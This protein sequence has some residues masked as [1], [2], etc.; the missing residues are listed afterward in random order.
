MGT[1]KALAGLWEVYRETEKGTRKHSLI[2][3]AVNELLNQTVEMVK[4]EEELKVLMGGGVTKEVKDY[5]SFLKD[6]LQNTEHC[7]DSHK[8]S[9]VCLVCEAEKMEERYRKK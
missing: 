9:T 5:R 7:E 2:G 3:K 4:I 1:N 8:Y 6:F